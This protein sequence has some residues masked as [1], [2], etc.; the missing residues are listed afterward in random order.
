MFWILYNLH[1]LWILRLY[2]IDVENVDF[3]SCDLIIKDCP[4]FLIFWNYF[5]SSKM[6]KNTWK[7]HET[8]Y[9]FPSEK[10]RFMRHLSLSP[11]P[12]SG[13]MVHLSGSNSNPP[14]SAGSS[15]CHK[16]VIIWQRLLSCSQ[17]LEIRFWIF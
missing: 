11:V 12:K 7:N 9:W 4:K 2:A 17:F 5:C 13:K 6:L 1:G 10:W 3:F 8:F 14:V 15:I 16:Y